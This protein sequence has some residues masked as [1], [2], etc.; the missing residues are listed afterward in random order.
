MIVIPMAGLSSRF[1]KAGYTQ[2]KYALEAHG[3]TLFYYSVGSFRAYA[4]TLPFL[5][6]TLARYDATRF[7]R[8]EAARLGISELRIVELDT[9]TR[10]QAETVSRGLERAGVGDEPIT[11]FNIDSCCPGFRFPAFVGDC[12]GYLQ[13]F[14]GSGPNWSYAR[15]AAGPG[16]RVAETAE[17]NPISDLCSTG[18]YH[19]RSAAGFQA[20]Y[21]AQSAAGELQ[22]N[23][24]YVAPLYNRLIALGQDIRYDLVSRDDLV[25]FGTPEEYRAVDAAPAPP[26]RAD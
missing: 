23:E 4:D 11:V 1:F 17:K 3:H 10:G 8:T 24:L 16:N 26:F 13:V 5:F 20:A 19:F 7:I 21:A 2:P 25:F 22:H 12:D 15:P 6:V 14:H 9:A 18:L